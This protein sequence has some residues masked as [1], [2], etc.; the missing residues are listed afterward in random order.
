M[1]NKSS[2]ATGQSFYLFLVSFQFFAL[3]LT[4]NN[5]CIHSSGEYKMFPKCFWR[6]YRYI[7]FMD[8]LR[9]YLLIKIYF[10]CW[11]YE[12]AIECRVKRQRDSFQVLSEFYT[13]DLDEAW[14]R[15][16]HDCSY[17]TPIHTDNT[18]TETI[19]RVYSI[20]SCF[21][22]KY[23]NNNYWH[24]NRYYVCHYRFIRSFFPLILPAGHECACL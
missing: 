18:S 11:T 7:I 13:Y 9:S 15:Y 14:I 10:V 22:N 1:L 4:D 8:P 23:N 16:V 20:N 12:Q 21:C 19:F 5:I 6:S 2:F 24:Y 17:T 3:T